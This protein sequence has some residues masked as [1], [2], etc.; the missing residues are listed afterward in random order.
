MLSELMTEEDKYY[1]ISVV[2]GIYKAEE[3]NHVY[4]GT[5]GWGNYRDVGL[6]V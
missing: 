3:E 2:C 1:M 4:Q 5:E 6:S